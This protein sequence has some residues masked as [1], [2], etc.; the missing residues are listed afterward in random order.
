MCLLSLS[1]NVKKVHL[2]CQQ[3][4]QP[5]VTFSYVWPQLFLNMQRLMLP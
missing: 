4:Q 5:G 2:I 3:L 1:S